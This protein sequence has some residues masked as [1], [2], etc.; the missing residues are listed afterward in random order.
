MLADMPGT[1]QNNLDHALTADALRRDAVRLGILVV[2]SVTV[3]VLDLRNAVKI[4]MEIG[5]SV[6]LLMSLIALII[7]TK[8]LR[9]RRAGAKAAVAAYGV[10]TAALIGSLF[11]LLGA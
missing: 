3:A 8:A 10:M 4:V 5:G 2:L 6:G 7:A 11:L 1:I 9:D